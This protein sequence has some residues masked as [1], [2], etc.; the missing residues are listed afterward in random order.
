MGTKAIEI[1][2]GDVKEL[3]D[4]LNRALA[5]EWLAVYQYWVGSYVIKGP[6]RSEIEEELK[7]H[8][9]EELEHAEKLAERIIQLGGVPILNPADFSKMSNCG[10]EEPSQPDTK[11][12][13]EQNI[14]GEQCAIGVYN[15]I[16]EKLKGM[17][18]AITYNMIRKI[19]QDEVKHEQE[20]Q[21]L[22]EDLELMM[23]K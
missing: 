6:M 20:L 13:L 17:N 8:A 16:L 11:I 5:D 2:K 9:K 1:I 18:D 7:E 12:I 15:T 23:K 3:I 4:L 14:K 22:Q 10:Y 19:M 21:D